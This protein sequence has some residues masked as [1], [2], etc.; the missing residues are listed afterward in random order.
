MTL[1]YFFVKCFCKDDTFIQLFMS[2]DVKMQHLQTS[3]SFV[4][5]PLVNCPFLSL[6]VNSM[7]DICQ[8][9]NILLPNKDFYWH[10]SLH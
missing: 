9:G 8:R 10:L 4:S 5:H 1:I 2:R 3:L 6:L 7:T